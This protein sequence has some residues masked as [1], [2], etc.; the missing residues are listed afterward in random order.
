[1]HEE[2]HGHA[3]RH[4]RGLAATFRYLRLLPELWRSDVG[5]E[6]VRAVA[7]KPGERVVDLGAGMGAATFEAA[8]TGATVFAVDPTP[9]MRGILRLRRLWLGRA[10]VTVLN[11]A[12]E[13]IPLPDATIEALWTVNT[14]HHWTDRPRACRELA[15]I[16][17]P[18]GR[19]FLVDEDMDDPRHPWHERWKSRGPRFDDVAPESIAQA[20]TAAGFTTAHSRL[21]ILA[22][23]PAKIIQAT[24]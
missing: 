4:D 22:S 23:R 15:R 9:L 21:T 16:L 8:R 12:A 7:P 6:V 10:A 14:I 1:M 18:G 17:R 2:G 11:G 19:V 13:A 3:H 24:R 20:L 5:A